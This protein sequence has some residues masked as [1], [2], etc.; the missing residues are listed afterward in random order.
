[1]NFSR[2]ND[3]AIDLEDLINEINDNFTASLKNSLTPLVDRVNSINRIYG[4]IVE[5]VGKMP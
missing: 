4:A 1:M 5:S 3:K 2:E